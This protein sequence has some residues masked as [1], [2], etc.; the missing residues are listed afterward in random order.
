[1][2]VMPGFTNHQELRYTW[3][4]MAGKIA[5]RIAVGIVC[6]W[7]LAFATLL[8]FYAVNPWIDHKEIPVFGS[9]ASDAALFGAAG[10][11]CVFVIR[12]FIQG[13]R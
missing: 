10:L 1:M 3:L 8:F 9:R 6:C 12:R 11:M 5:A 4:E 7:G 2:R 13:R